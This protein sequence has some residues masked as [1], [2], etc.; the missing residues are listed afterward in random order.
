MRAR[1][2]TAVW[3]AGILVASLLPPE[4]GRGGWHW[5]LLGYGVLALL[6]ATWLPARAAAAAA[7]SYGAVIEG[8]QW[9]VRYRNADVGDLLVNA[10]GAVVGVLAW[11]VWRRR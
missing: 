2:L 10:A 6:L 8:L 5:H 3:M 9:V 1:A 4:F 7:W 11:A